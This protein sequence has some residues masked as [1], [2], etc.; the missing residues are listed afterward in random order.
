MLKLKSVNFEQ[1]EFQ[2]YCLTQERS[3]QRE[4]SIGRHPSCDLVLENPEVSRT[5]G[6]ILY[7]DYAYHLMDDGS[8]S[9]TI[10]SGEKIAP[11]VKQVLSLGD[12]IQLGE[13]LLYVEELVPL[14][15]PDLA[16]SNDPA[17]AL[18][19]AWSGNLDC[20]CCRIIDETPDVKTFSF[21][22]EPGILF[23]FQ[24]G[25]FV[26][27]A[28]E[29]EGQ[30]VIRPY[31]IS[32][33]PTRPYH[34][35]ITIKRVPN[36]TDDA[37]AGLVSNWMH[38]QFKVGDRLQ[39]LGGP[40]GR[41]TCL[42]QEPPRLPPSKM[43]LI[44]AGSGITP[45]MSMSRWVQDQLI[46]CDVVFLHSARSPE[47]LIFQR[48]LELMDAQMPN[49]R[50][51]V[52]VTQRSLGQPWMGLTGRISE[53]MLSLVVPD[54][55]ERSVYICG[56]Q[57]FM[58]A[59][60][61]TLTEMG[62]PMEKYQEESFGGAPTPVATQRSPMQQEIA[63]LAAANSPTQLPVQPLTITYKTPKLIDT[64]SQVS[65]TFMQSGCSVETDGKTTVLALAEEAGVAIASACR[66]GACGA[67][68]VRINQGNVAYATT[69]QAITVT[70]QAEGYALA[71][72]AYPSDAIE[73]LA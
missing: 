45:M 31:S 32:S 6:R 17:P 9:G 13:T 37:P 46:D 23:H 8:S 42:P 64:K 71:C 20:R 5:H 54:W 68:K 40:M 10:L 66:M 44:S 47:D 11:Q 48:E 15:R 63:K 41:F 61:T 57:G 67:C 58:S 18:G 19:T 35:S 43:L 1:S 16:P 21:I 62:F 51:A 50:L 73:V 28:V 36:A 59:V 33:S 2:N 26:R 27:L 22:A 72:I 39:L 34:L 70:E 25:Q 3:G 52:T 4:W 65:V 49:F 55:S 38:D 7:R 24:P 29:I 69:P 30:Q 14:D 56:S 12:L 60:K 53:A